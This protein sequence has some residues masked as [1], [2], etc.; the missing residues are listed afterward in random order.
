MSSLSLGAYGLVAVIVLLVLRVPIGVALGGVGFVGIWLFAGPRA[1]WGMLSEVPYEFIAHWTLSS[2][3]MFLLM[4]YVAFHSGI[5][6]GIFNAARVWMGRLPG[7][8]AVAT[9]SGAAGF[10]AVT[11]SSI[12]SAAAMGRIAVPEMTRNG[13]DP[14]L[15]TG[16]VA[17]A[18]TIGAMI[19]P[20]ILMIIFGIFAEVSIARLFMGGVIPGLLTAAFFCAVIV[21]RVRMRPSLAP[22]LAR[23]PTWGEKFASLSGVWPFAVLVIGVIGGLFGGIFTPTE[24]GAVGASLA[25]LISLAQGK[26][27]WPLFVTSVRETLFSTAAV[28][29]IAMG[30]ALL[31][32]FLSFTGLPATLSDLVTAMDLGVIPLIFAIALLY[33]FL[34]MF[35]D[36][37]GCMLLTLP[38]LLPIL[39]TQQVDLIW[40]GS[41]LVKFLEI[42]LITPPVGLNVFVIKGVVG[43]I[44][45]VATIFRGVIWF[46]LADVAL[47]VLLILLPDLVMFLPGLMD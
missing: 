36:P 17:A 5:T 11:G 24:A 43:N 6:V 33:V 22:G 20:S 13:Y 26:L 42:G 34:G 1:A 8:L 31:T 46:L 21:L 41:L 30:A 47:V 19:P 27:T 32:R 14:G 4:G 9:V 37:L 3:P 10:A 16:T 38:I 25:I 40:F 7:G 12:A 15:A 18:G 28:F 45:S 35:L 44:A 29:F 39:E 23:R 2:V